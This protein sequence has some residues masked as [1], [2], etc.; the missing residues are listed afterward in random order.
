MLGIAFRRGRFTL[1]SICLLLLL[2]LYGCVHTSQL[3]IQNQKV[4]VSEIPAKWKSKPVVILDSHTELKFIKNRTANIVKQKDIKW[5]FI[6]KRNPNWWENISLYDHGIFEKPLNVKATAHYPDGSRWR[7]PPEKIKRKKIDF[8]NTF[9]NSF[10]IPKYDKGVIIQLEVRRTYF[11][12]EFISTFILRHNSPTLHRKIT[13]ILPESSQIVF[14]LE[15]QESANVEQTYAI[16]NGQKTISITADL[17]PGRM[18]NWQTEFPEQ[19]YAAVHVSFPPKGNQSF[20]WQQLGDHYLEQAGEAFAASTAIKKLGATIQGQSKE[21]IIKDAFST[22]VN[23]VRYHGDWEGRFGYFPRKAK[24]IMD[25]GYGD[26]K[27][28]STLLYTLLKTKSINTRLSMISTW[29]HYQPHTRYPSF[30]NFNHMILA[31][32]N[33]KNQYNYLDGTHYWA[34]AKNSYYNLIGRTAFV[35]EPGNSRLVRISQGDSFK[36]RV[37][38]RTKLIQ[39]GK[40]GRWMIKGKIKLMGFPALRFFSYLNGSQSTYKAGLIK[41]F[42]QTQF[43]ILP[44]HAEV[45]SSNCDKAEITYKAHFQKNYIAL[46]KGGFKLALPQLYQ[47]AV[48][49]QL[50]EKFGPVFMEPFEQQD[51]WELPT[52]PK[53]KQLYGFDMAFAHQQWSGKGT[54]VTRSYWQLAQTFDSDDEHLETWSKHCKRSGDNLIWN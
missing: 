27:E 53:N 8:H 3:E 47:Q 7:L 5:V 6:N 16:E 20:S 25:Q 49:D 9:R 36:S 32:P 24:V 46:G 51:S 26:C 10:L 19:W 45:Q 40:S 44:I 38:T 29:T 14:G 39:E 48:D 33:K 15:N 37:T 34:N 18:P 1:S 52:P 35:L 23:K 31:C 2:Q 28:I 4:K 30:D 11:Q 41:E 21:E 50:V 43:G 17:L 13:L 42:L 54:H 12:P 22:I